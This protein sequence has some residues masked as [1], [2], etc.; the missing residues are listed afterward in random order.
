MSR[1]TSAVSPSGVPEPRLAGLL[2]DLDQ[3]GVHGRVDTGRIAGEE[4][5]RVRAWRD[6]GTVTAE[7][8]WCCPGQPAPAHLDAVRVH[9]RHRQVWRSRHGRC[10]PA[11]CARFLAD[12][13][14]LDNDTLR[15]RY[16]ALG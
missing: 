4:D 3:L 16:Q 2:A 8:L 15:E 11:E 5:V 10:Q 13:L 1:S 9:G 14:L 7:L 12:L 6:G